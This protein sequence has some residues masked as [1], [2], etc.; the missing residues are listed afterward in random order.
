MVHISN[1]YSSIVK[2]FIAS[3]GNMSENQLVCMVKK[4]LIKHFGINKGRERVLTENLIHT[5]VLKRNSMLNH[6]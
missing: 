5:L 3:C 6:I 4:F 2:Y 1:I